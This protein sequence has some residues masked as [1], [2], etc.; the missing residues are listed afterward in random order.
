MVQHEARERVN[1]HA[2]FM[3]AYIRTVGAEFCAERQTIA[4]K[5]LNCSQ[6][7]K[8]SN[9][10]SL[11]KRAQA[12]SVPLA[13]GNSGNP[14]P[15]PPGNFFAG[16]IGRVPGAMPA[17]VDN[18]AWMSTSPR[19]LSFFLSSFLAFFFSACFFFYFFFFC[20]FA[21]VFEKKLTRGSRGQVI[22]RRDAFVTSLM[23]TT[24][25]DLGLRTGTLAAV[26]RGK[27]TLRVILSYIGISYL[28]LTGDRYIGISW[29]FLF[30]SLFF[31]FYTRVI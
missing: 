25:T 22:T 26:S 9:R 8:R 20:L 28:V 19:L 29:F 23:K 27:E 31:F 30:L 15:L 17:T 13:A 16:L 14:P 4:A 2:R 11:E 10:I 1:A 5:W 3:A 18:S 6:L 7:N 24:N 21:R 12:P